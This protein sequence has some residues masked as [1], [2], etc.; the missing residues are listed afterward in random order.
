MERNGKE[1]KGM[2]EKGF[3]ERLVGSPHP[4]KGDEI[5]GVSYG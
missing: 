1:W 4:P 2:G 3:Y 5:G